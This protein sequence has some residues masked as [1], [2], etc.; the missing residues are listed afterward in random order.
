M[1]LCDLSPKWYV[2]HEGGPRVGFT[3]LCPHC[4]AHRM[5]IAVHDQGHRIITEAEEDTHAPR[6]GFVWQ[7]TGGTDFHDISVTPSVDGSSFGCWHGFI[8]NGECK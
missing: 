6:A 5:G 8:T 2:L 3:F 1:R 4:R 7:I